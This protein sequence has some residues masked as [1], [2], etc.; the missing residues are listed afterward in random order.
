M[1]CQIY[2]FTMGPIVNAGKCASKLHIILISKSSNLYNKIPTVS[3]PSSSII[4]IHIPAT[5][6]VIY[7]ILFILL[8]SL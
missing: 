1:M 2:N 6:P 8:F 7:D 3:A 4:E 5:A